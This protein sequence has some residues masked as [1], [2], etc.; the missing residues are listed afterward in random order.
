MNTIVYH[1]KTKSLSKNV[2]K[3]YEIIGLLP[4]EIRFFEYIIMVIN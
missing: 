4:K 1:V 2:E 3:E